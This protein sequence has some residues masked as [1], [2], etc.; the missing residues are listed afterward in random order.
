MSQLW[1]RKREIAP[2]YATINGLPQD[3]EGGGGGG[4][5]VNPREIWHF[6]GFKCQFPHPWVSIM[7]QIPTPGDHRPCK[8]SKLKKW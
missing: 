6:Q 1:T 4:G 8:I 3:E 2:I 7:S 5:A